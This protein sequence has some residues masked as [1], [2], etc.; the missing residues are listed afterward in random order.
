M[1][2]ASNFCDQCGTRLRPNEV[3]P[4]CNPPS[5][6]TQIR[7]GDAA[8]DRSRIEV[9]SDGPVSLESGD[10]I[11]D[12]SQ[13]KIT[14][15]RADPGAPAAGGSPDDLGIHIQ[16]GDVVEDHSQTFVSVDQSTHTTIIQGTARVRYKIERQLTTCEVLPSFQAEDEQ[17]TD[18]LLRRLPDSLKEDRKSIERIRTELKRVYD[19]IHGAARGAA[20]ARCECLQWAGE[21]EGHLYLRRGWH[22]AWEPWEP[23]SAA[24]W[25]QR[26]EPYLDLIDSLKPLIAGHKGVPHGMLHPRNI[27]VDDVTDAFTLTEYGLFEVLRVLRE[28][29]HIRGDET[30]AGSS[31]YV[32]WALPAK[33]AR[34][35]Y[36]LGMLLLNKEYQGQ[37]T[38]E[39]IQALSAAPPTSHG[40]EK[41]RVLRAALMGGYASV[42]GLAE[43][44]ESAVSYDA[45]AAGEGEAL[46]GMRAVGDGD[47]L[48]YYED[49]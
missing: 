13:T 47:I 15:K 9:D 3:C 29:K 46:A 17:G 8:E 41:L 2:D 26:D 18:F 7:R 14:S 1:P 31:P 19:S 10:R 43:D 24:L 34:D 36:A 20:A 30:G 35:V 48:G 6:G 23:K 37:A 11:V 49:L 28:A 44:F 22:D 25:P 4:R 27:H 5:A 38:P 40:S 12:A 45:A 32:N 16:K 39:V 42:D 21:V 33:P